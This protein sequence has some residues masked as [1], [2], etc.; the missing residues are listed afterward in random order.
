VVDV[1]DAILTLMDQSSAMGEVF[2][3]GHHEEISM[4][5]SGRDPCREPRCSANSSTAAASFDVE[6]RRGLALSDLGCQRSGRL[7]NIKHR[8]RLI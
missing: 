3:V 7:A 8:G 5:E 4:L 6:G 2:N 1:V